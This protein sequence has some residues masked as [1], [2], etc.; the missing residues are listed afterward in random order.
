LIRMID[1]CVQKSA[2]EISRSKGTTE[3]PKPYVMKMSCQYGTPQ[4]WF[5]QQSILRFYSV[6]PLLRVKKVFSFIALLVLLTLLC[7]GAAYGAATPPKMRP[8]SGIGIVVLPDP[9]S[10]TY[11]GEATNLYEEPGILRLGELDGSGTPGNAWVFGVQKDRVPLIVVARKGN[12][13]RVCYDDA[14][15]EAW[16]DT[17]RRGAFQSWEQFFKGRVISLLPGLRKQYYQLYQEP[18]RNPLSTLTPIQKFKVLNLED[19]WVTVMSDQSTTG[20][21]RWRDE[22]GRIL[23][24]SDTD[25]QQ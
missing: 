9:D 18:D 17:Q 24:S 25:L 6:A 12:W 4:K 22:D 2:V 10:G 16:V 5:F 21:L 7:T 8:Y 3:K 20:W 1:G 14:G 23:V 11:R 19:D 15:R 13:L